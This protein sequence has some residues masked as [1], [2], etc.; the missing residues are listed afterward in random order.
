MEG[1][2]CSE[3]EYGGA[4][5]STKM[6][7]SS[8]PVSHRNRGMS[9]LY[10]GTW[11]VERTMWNSEPASL[12]AGANQPVQTNISNQMVSFVFLL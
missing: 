12:G 4:R 1:D 3:E 8:E 7:V 10:H 2:A 6:S 5:S 9:S 11:P